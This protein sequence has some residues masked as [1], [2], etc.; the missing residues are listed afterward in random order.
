MTENFTNSSTHE[1]N[2]ETPK[3]GLNP[4]YKK[5]SINPDETERS[6]AAHFLEASEQLHHKIEAAKKME[7][8]ALIDPMTD[9]YNRSF[10][11][12]YEES[13]FDPK[14]DHNKIGIVYVDMNNL[15]EINDTYGHEVGDEEICKMVNYLKSEFRKGDE[16]I[17]MGGDEFIILCHNSNNDSK[18]YESL[19]EKINRISAKY[20]S[21]AYIDEYNQRKI[22]FA[23]GVAVYDA[24]R[25]TKL[26][27][28]INRADSSMYENKK[29][30][31]KELGKIPEDRKTP[32]I[33]GKMKQAFTSN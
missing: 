33:L 19:I 26:S 1:I 11:M 24:N 29:E 13:N 31:K 6:S 14:R 7:T 4:D 27:D 21:K 15:K 9:C 8:T 23:C 16:I 10:Y 2:H 28:T 12:R 20:L 5:S 3:R 18:F 32:S 30:V 22:S 25:D 17:R